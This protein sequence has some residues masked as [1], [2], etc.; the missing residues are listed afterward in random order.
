[1]RTRG[2][3]GD[4][5]AAWARGPCSV[6][7]RCWGSRLGRE[8]RSLFHLVKP[9]CPSVQEGEVKGVAEHAIQGRQRFQR[10]KLGVVKAQVAG[11]PQEGAHRG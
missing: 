6:G 5:D 11:K 4:C 1:M 10:R 7:E 8:V 2:S 9:R 3:E